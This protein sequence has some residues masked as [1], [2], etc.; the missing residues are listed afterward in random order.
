MPR[1]K[2]GTHRAARRKKVLEQ[3]S[4]YYGSKHRL[5]LIARR[6]LEKSLQYAYR[7]RRVRK[8]E[9]RALWIVRINAACRMLGLK[10]SE[11]IKSLKDKGVALDRKALAYIAAN[12]FPT[13]KTIVE[14]VRA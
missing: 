10:Y 12:D 2:R 6:Q 3:A 4:G 14:Q 13:F 1:V 7:D 8:R 9:F 11:L 5:H